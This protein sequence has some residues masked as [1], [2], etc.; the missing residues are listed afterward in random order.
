MENHNKHGGYIGDGNIIDYSVNINPFGISPRLKENIIKKLNSL[1]SYPEINGDSTKEK[2]SEYLSIDKENT[3][4]GNGATE[5]IYLFIRA[6]NF[7]EIA[8]LEP[9]FTEYER[10]AVLNQIKVVKLLDYDEIFKAD[11][12]DCLFICN[13]NNPTGK[14]L[15]EIEL[16]S[17]LKNA[18]QKDQIVFIDESFIEFSDGRTA[19]DYIEEYNL[20]ILRSITKIYGVPGL[21]VGFGIGSKEIIKKMDRIKEPWSINSLALDALELYLIDEDYKKK[22]LEWYKREKRRMYLLLKSIEELEVFDSEAN[23]FMIKMNISDGNELKKYCLDRGIYIRVCED[24][25]S[26]D[27]SYIR[28]AIRLEHENDIIVELI[29]EFFK[30]LNE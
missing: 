29:R 18:K 6:M 14:L 5:L 30:S 9:T 26:L 27:K 16:E 17:I 25:Y 20:F 23:F 10:A 2:L 3:I 8:I 28:I 12:I 1:D 24:F 22:T 15:S 11:S 4:I 21:R 7:K 13:P 19:K